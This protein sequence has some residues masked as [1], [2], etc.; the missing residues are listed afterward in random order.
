MNDRASQLIA[1]ALDQLSAALAAGHSQALTTVLTMM[2]RFRRYSVSNQVLIAVQRPEATRVAGFRTWLTLGRH[3]RKGEKGI[4]ILAPMLRRQS[5]IDEDDEAPARRLGG[6]RTVFVF[7]VG[8]TDGEPLP[9]VSAPDGDPGLAIQRL[10]ACLATRGISCELVSSISGAPTAQGAS[11]G[12]RIEIRDDMSP[13]ETLT[14]L[15]HEAAHELLH[16]DRTVVRPPHVVRELEA[17]A[18]ACVVAE[19][20]GLRAIAATADYVLLHQGS[21]E[22]L[23]LSLGRIRRVAGELLGALDERAPAPTEVPT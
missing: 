16:Q 12:G 21:A 1:T 11:Y 9:T 2:A 18:V 19:A 3:V 23:A 4:A 5:A 22:L 15:L 17:D 20:L 13:A 6:F 10:E 14:T 7:D 8:Q